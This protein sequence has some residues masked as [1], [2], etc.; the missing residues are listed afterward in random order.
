MATKK[1][2]KRM[3][4]KLKGGRSRSRTSASSSKQLTK[5]MFRTVVS[6][7]AFPTWKQW[8]YLPNLLTKQEK[9]IAR[10]SLFAILISLLFMGGVDISANQQVVAAFG[11]DYTEGLV[12]QPGFINP[13]YALNSDVDSDLAALVYSGLMK[14]EGGEYLPDLAESFD[15]SDDGLTYTFVL[16]DNVEWHDG[17]PLRMRDVISTFNMIQN[18]EYKSP[19]Q[20]IFT[21]IEIVQIDERTVQFN[22]DEPFTPFLSNLTVGIMPAHIWDSIPTRSTT[23]ADANL[24]PV[25]TGPYAFKKF[26]KDRFGNIFSYTL[27]AHDR[28]YEDSAFIEEIVFRFFTDTGSAYAALSNKQVDGL[29]FVPYELR[30][31]IIEDRRIELVTPHLLQYNA[32]FFNELAQEAFEDADVREAFSY[33]IDEER[34]VLSTLNNQGRLIDS[35]LLEGTPGYETV[36]VTFS[37]D[38]ARDRLDNA[39]WTLDDGEQIRSNASG[40]LLEVTIT[41]LD[42]SE[43][44]LVANAI[45][46]QLGVVG[47]DVSIELLSSDA[48][49]SIVRDRAY[50][51][52]LGGHIYTGYIDPYPFWD[53]SQTDYPGLNFS[54]YNNSDVDSALSDVRENIDEEEQLEAYETIRTE[55][56]TDLPAI[57]LYQPTY[58]YA[59][60]SKIRG[61]ETPDIHQPFERFNTIESWFVKVKRTLQ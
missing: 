49:Q 47:I 54:L 13:L 18:I 1:P 17:N 28:Y 5:Q 38:E 34:I 6:K 9:S 59:V 43:F 50:E 26:S 44:E 51:I 56:M 10:F 37:V 2:F 4:R 36:E 48:F 22:L 55:L 61:I 41:T 24:R 21:D 58:A 27:E 12:G 14:F 46:E 33:A 29:G 16:R 23:L 15:L 35:P 11:G 53:S 42:S 60:P 8:Q 40:E 32:L 7:R 57:F 45:R 25:G 20:S 31:E 52:L 39:G 30:E 3:S 19:L